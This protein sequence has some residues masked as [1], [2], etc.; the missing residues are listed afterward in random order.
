[1]KEFLSRPLPRAGCA[2]VFQ[3]QQPSADLA[4]NLAAGRRP[5][6]AVNTVSTPLVDGTT[7]GSWLDSIFG[8]GQGD[9]RVRLTLMKSALLLLALAQG[10]PQFA[11]ADL[12]GAE[13]AQFAAAALVA[14]R[15]L[16]GLLQPPTFTAAREVEWTNEHGAAPSWGGQ[17]G[18]HAVLAMRVRAG[19]AVGASA[20]VVINA[21][22]DAVTSSLPATQ[23]TALWHVLLDSGADMPY[24]VCL[25]GRGRQLSMGS[26]YTLAPKSVLLLAADAPAKSAASG[27][28]GSQAG[29]GARGA[30]TA[31]P[32]A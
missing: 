3:A 28:A 27:G 14:R 9:G 32:H 15:R 16:A 19:G 18:P 24:D 25:N 13:L 20:C 31:G 10:T 17:G 23:G 26:S 1:M 2:E 4:G 5:S 7:L 12:E 29:A 21:G 11:A 8:P 22:W 6:F 30:A